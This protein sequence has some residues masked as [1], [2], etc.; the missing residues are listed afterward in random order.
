MHKGLT[1]GQ[2]WRRS[3]AKQK[4]A[5]T[6]PQAHSQKHKV[7]RSDTTLNTHLGGSR[8]WMALLCRPPHQAQG[9]TPRSPSSELSQS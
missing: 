7:Q 1:A 8:C 2:V 3:C 6:T 5:Q 4:L 9:C